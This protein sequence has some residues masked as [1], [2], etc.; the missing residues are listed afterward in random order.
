MSFEL[1]KCFSKENKIFD[2][3]YEIQPEVYGDD[4][5][6]FIEVFSEK[7]FSKAGL[8]VK[9]VQ[10]NQSF[11]KKGVLR[12]LHFQTV[13]PQGKLIHVPCGKIYDV[14][15][16]LRKG[17]ETFGLYYGTVLDSQKHNALY[18]PGGFAHG[19]YAVTDALVSY[20]CTDFY[21]PKGEG[22]LMWNDPALCVDWKQFL[23][24]NTPFLSRKDMNYPPFNAAFDYFKAESVSE[25]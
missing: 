12:G 9:F 15:V 10:D 20:K 1:K 13:H 11:S 18:I 16:D 2:G 6:F 4:R 24:D 25:N 7:E 23:F 21:D 22:G 19:F 5:G 14:A 3:L 17:S 8:N